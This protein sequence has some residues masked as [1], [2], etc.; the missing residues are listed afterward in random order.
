MSGKYRDS[1]NHPPPTPGIAQWV[2]NSLFNKQTPS[3]KYRH[4]DDY[5]NDKE[6]IE[7]FSQKDEARNRQRESSYLEENDIRLKNYYKDRELL[8]DV[9]EN[10]T[11]HRRSRSMGNLNL[12]NRQK[13][14]LNHPGKFP[15]PYVKSQTGNIPSSPPLLSSTSKN[16]KLANVNTQRNRNIIIDSSPVVIPDRTR[17]EAQGTSGEDEWEILK[18]VDSNNADLRRLTR[19]ING[20]RLK[21][22]SRSENHRYRDD[23]YLRLEAKYKDVRAELVTELKKS[24]KLYDSYYKFVNK[25]KR[26]KD[27]KQFDIDPNSQR[28]VE[29]LEQKLL[30]QQD[31]HKY[32]KSLLEEKIHLLERRLFDQE[33]STKEELRKKEQR[34]I[35]LEQKLEMKREETIGS[36]PDFSPFKPHSHIKPEADDTLDLINRKYPDR[37]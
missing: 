12:S 19:D 22:N 25:Y 1:I 37:I 28:K 27:E 32:D 18:L 33:Q 7:T 30:K 11:F 29:H 31:S 36:G 5:N 9:P 6:N 13:I 15:S 17:R 8:P 23:D 21:S 20:M 34:I 16:F 14:S 10:D 24:Q 4:Y 2:F 26:L 35:E 3:H